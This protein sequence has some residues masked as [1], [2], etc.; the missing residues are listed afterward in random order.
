M[1]IVEHQ[2]D[3]TLTN[4]GT[5]DT[6]N[7]GYAVFAGPLMKSLR[8]TIAMQPKGPYH[9]SFD[10]GISEEMIDEL[11]ATFYA[12]V[13]QDPLLGPVFTDILGGNWDAHLE[14]VSAFWR[15]ATRLDRSY[16]G[17][18]F[19]PAHTKHSQIQGSLMPRWLSLFR[20]TARDV[21]PKRPAD[22]LIDIADRMSE[23]IK[24]SLAR[25]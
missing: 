15:H 11:V 23:S 5:V 25:R 13:R 10:A 22:Q 18:D 16:E 6:R 20:K 17:R 3:G 24:M 7:F 14:K 12:R 19:I 21:C 4:F 9:H 8:S 1:F 2:P